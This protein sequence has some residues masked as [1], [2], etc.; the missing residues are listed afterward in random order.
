MAARLAEHQLGE[1][2]GFL[3]KHNA[4]ALKSDETWLQRLGAL[5]SL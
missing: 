5:Q 1:I 2:A 4:G 3:Q